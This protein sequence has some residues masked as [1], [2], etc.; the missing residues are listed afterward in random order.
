MSASAESIVEDAAL[1]RLE[2]LDDLVLQGPAIG[3]VA[4]AVALLAGWGWGRAAGIGGGGSLLAG[5]YWSGLERGLHGCHHHY[6][7][8]RCALARTAYRQLVFLELRDRW[9]GLAP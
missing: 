7:N 3:F 4:A 6:L 9:A 1:G 2:M 5:A 8:P